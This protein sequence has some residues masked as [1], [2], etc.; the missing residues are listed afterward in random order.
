MN[1]ADTLNDLRIDSFEESAQTAGIGKLP[2]ADDLLKSTVALKNF[3]FAEA[4]DSGH[5]SIEDSQD[6]L[7]RV[8]ITGS[9]RERDLFL[10]IPF[11]SEFLAKLMNK[12]DA[13][14]VS[15]IVLSQR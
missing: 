14:K 3:R 7:D 1:F 11:D 4:V 10:Q 8:I 12:E 15:Q 9:L 2:Y 6:Q 13:P 5:Q